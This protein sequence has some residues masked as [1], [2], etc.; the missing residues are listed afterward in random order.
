MWAL[1]PE[2]EALKTAYSFYW[3]SFQSSM[4]MQALNT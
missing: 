2:V 1:G 4:L 3:N